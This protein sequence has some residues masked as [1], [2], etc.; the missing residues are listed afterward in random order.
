MKKTIL[1][2]VCLVISFS[3]WHCS[4]KPDSRKIHVLTL[5][6]EGRTEIL[7]DVG[8]RFLRG[9]AEHAEMVDFDDSSWRMLNLPHDWSIEDIPGTDS[10][11][12]PDAIGGI[13]AGY[14]VGGTGW[15]RKTFYL[16]GTIR[17]KQVHLQF[18][19]IYMNADVWLNGKLLGNHP[20]GYTSFWYDITEQILP[21][22]ENLLAV[23]VKNEGRNSRWYS[24]SGIYRHVW[25]NV[26]NPLH[27][28][29]WGTFITTP[30]VDE[31]MARVDISTSVFNK[32]GRDVEVLMTTKILDMNGT[33]IT[34]SESNSPVPAN[35]NGIFQTEFEIQEPQLWSVESPCLYKA[36]VEIYTIDGEKRSGLIDKTETNFGIRYFSMSTADGFLL[37]GKPL[38]LK[39]ACMHHDNG[40]LGAAA[41]DRAEERRV[42][43]MKASGYNA[44]RC[45]HNPPSPAFLEACD[46]LGM[47]VINEAFDMWREPKNPQDYYLYFDDWWEKD[48]ESMVLRDRNHP[49][50]IFWSIGNEIPERGKP[51]GAVL[52]NT[53]A[54]H[55]RKLDPTRPV[56]SAVNNVTPDKDP[57]F[58]ALDVCGYN[59][60]IDKYV[61]DAQRIPDRI[62]YAAE[63]YP[64]EAFDYWM[65]VLDHPRVI[66]DFVWTGFDYL[67]EASIGWLGYP[68][69]GSFFPWNHA[70]C[71]DID[72]CG[73]KRPPS[74]YRDVLWGDGKQVSIFVTPPSPSFPM[75]PNKE[76]WSK[77]EWQ[78]VVAHWNWAGSEGKMLD[79]EVYSS[80]PEVELFLNEKSLGKK[81]TDRR[82]KWIAR[83]KLPYTPGVVR[84][85]GYDGIAQVA[86]A[87]LI[88]ADKPEKLL[89]TADRNSIVADGQD[90]SYVTVEILDAK[91]VRNPL[92]ENLVQFEIDG[93][94]SIHAV[95]S[96]NPMSNE[97][98]RQPRRKTYQGRC[99]VIIKSEKSAGEIRLKAFSEGLSPAEIVISSS[100][101]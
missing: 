67:G 33:L 50:V 44:I 48:I 81:T 95:G 82:N 80:C 28:A 46:R 16:P 51:E 89:Q 26:M 88:T 56:T 31:E 78:D 35:E 21:G 87:E 53:L 27:L 43:L 93:P 101:R 17:G 100:G 59:Y 18:D 96:S 70:Y 32:S 68:H 91:G 47:L 58:A 24:G 97:S 36:I 20:Y 49:S 94:G 63:S 6:R 42:E 55:I 76:V 8:W 39:G 3:L 66:G 1:A 60:A 83:W 34:L 37:N 30:V 54:N 79:I 4:E 25:L 40:P 98:F 57:F 10:P 84:A 73:F 90:L 86:S 52:A 92:A 19:G 71:G 62:I 22:K 9:D 65:A 61:I 15:Y 75:N 41:F 12:D 5:N 74:Y 38:L 85:V 99:L 29:H 14:M 64:L 7:F 69:E 77:W 23:K 13:D 11:F 2:T 72:I 45:A